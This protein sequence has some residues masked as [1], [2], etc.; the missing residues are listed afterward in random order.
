MEPHRG[1]TDIYRLTRREVSARLADRNVW[2]WS[3]RPT[4][5]IIAVGWGVQPHSEFI[6][7]IPVTTV[8]GPDYARGNKR[9]RC[10]VSEDKPRSIERWIRGSKALDVSVRPKCRCGK[11]IL[12]V[13]HATH[14]PLPNDVRSPPSVHLL[15]GDGTG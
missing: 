13:D 11:T 12:P 9:Q 15:A 3:T 4:A 14:I 1:R 10:N 7:T 5:H 8:Y 6:Q 2:V